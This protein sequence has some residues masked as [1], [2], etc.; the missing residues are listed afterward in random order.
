MSNSKKINVET[1]FQRTQL[2]KGKHMQV[3]T[4]QLDRQTHLQSQVGLQ[5]NIMQDSGSNTIDN[6]SSLVISLQ[7]TNFS[8]T[9]LLASCGDCV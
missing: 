9:R 4:Q 8:L 7:P 1:K 6:N 2:P 5:K 3:A